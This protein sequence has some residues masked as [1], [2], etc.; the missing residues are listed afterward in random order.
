ML[1]KTILRSLYVKKKPLCCIIGKYLAL[2]ADFFGGFK[3]SSCCKILI[4]SFNNEKEGSLY[5]YSVDIL[6]QEKFDYN[7]INFNEESEK[8]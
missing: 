7:G 6:H 2:P 3:L 4:V 8:V 1:G 5:I